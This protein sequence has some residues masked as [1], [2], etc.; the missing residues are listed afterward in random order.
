MWD[1][2][3]YI[4]DN[5]KPITYD[6]IAKYGLDELVV[7]NR[8]SGRTEAA[9]VHES[10]ILEELYTKLK[11]YRLLAS[12]AENIKPYWVFTNEELDALVSNLPSSD[13]ELLGKKGFGKKKVEKSGKEILK[14]ISDYASS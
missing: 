12:R 9:A 1:I 13:D 14:I 5:H 7:K 3:N 2:A 4:K 8:N 10:P 6:Y 11:V